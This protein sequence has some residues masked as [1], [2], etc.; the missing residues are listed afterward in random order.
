MKKPICFVI[1]GFGKKTDYSIS[2]TYDLDKTYKNIIKPA[3]VA[4][5][6]E[7]IRADEIIESGLIDRSMYA[8]LVKA[9]LVIADITTYNP[10]AIYELGIRHGV[11]PYST[12]I[13]KEQEGK[14]EFD[15]SHDRIF[16]YKHLGEDIGTDEA[17]ECQEKLKNLILRIKDNPKSDSPLYELIK[18]ATPTTYA[19]DEYLEIIGDLANREK[20]LFAIIEKAE[21]EIKNGNY[22]NASNLFSKANQIAIDE[23]YYIQ[24]QALYKYKSK[25]P[26]ESVALTEAWAII[27]QL[28][29]DD[30]ID[31]ETLGISGAI[32]KRLYLLNGDLESLEKAIGYYGKGFNVY[33]NYYTGENY[34]NCLDL[35]AKMATDDDEITGLRY[36][37]KEARKKIIK[38][39]EAIPQEDLDARTDKMWIYATLSNCNLFLNEIEKADYFEGLFLSENPNEW[40]I[41]TFN[42]TKNQFINQ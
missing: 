20:G 17:N 16:S 38:N 42:K 29:P 6:Y 32:F 12:I 3:A 40:E 31:P 33:S 11:K 41:E 7:C 39:L 24:Q 2:K 10:N 4:A 26:S 36:M 9:D 27:R 18:S 37:S 35:K 21:E 14:R 8:L 34:A 25:S 19:E 28:N 30:S 13:L 1:M 23:S 15:F 22:L 5:G